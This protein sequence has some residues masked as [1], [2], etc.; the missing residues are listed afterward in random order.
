MVKKY[1]SM[2]DKVLVVIS[3][4]QSN[5]SKRFVKGR[6]V[7]PEQSKQIWDI[8]LADQNLNNVEVIVS[9]EASPVSAAFKMA[10]KLEPGTKLYLGASKK[11]G[12]HRRWGFAPKYIEDT[13]FLVNPLETAVEPLSRPDESGKAFSATDAREALTNDQD[14]DVFFGLGNTE[15]VREVLGINDPI[16]EMSAMGGG[17]VQGFL[18][19]TSDEEQESIIQ[20]VL[21]Y[22]YS[23]GIVI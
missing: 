21:D 7:T 4:P 18:G 14:A 1:A 22:L 23:Q 10:N 11:G 17:A 2:A 15:K 16:E 3:S 8:L 20:E 5:K 12:D 9:P 19:Y 6:P 13:V